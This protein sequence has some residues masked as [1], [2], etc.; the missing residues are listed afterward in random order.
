MAKRVCAEP[1]CPTL[2]NTTRCPTHTRAKDKARGKRAHGSGTDWAHTKLRRQWQQRMDAGEH[3]NCW[4]CG[5]PIN[6]RD[7]HLGHD[8]ADRTKYRGPEHPKCNLSAAGRA[9]HGL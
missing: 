5:H 4:R 6:P 8:D 2:T 1:G 3:V 9:R 7:W